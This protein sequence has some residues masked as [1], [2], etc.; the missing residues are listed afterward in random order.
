M[1]AV[2][3]VALLILLATSCLY[4]DAKLSWGPKLGFNLSQHYGTKGAEMDYKVR[5]GLRPGLAAGAFLEMEISENLSLM[6]ELLYT[7]KGSNENITVY[8]IDEAGDGVMVELPKPA[9]MK[10]KYY[11]DYIEIPVV[12]K[13]KMMDKPKFSIFTHA[14][15]AMSI[16]VKGY[17]QLDGKVYLTNGAGFD[18]LIV[19]AESKLAE[20]NMFDFSFVYGGE[21]VFKYKIPIHL[22]YRFTLGWDYLSLPTN[23]EYDPSSK[24]VE[25][26]NQ[27]YSLILG[28]RF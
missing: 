13:V 18:E 7:Q 5:T 28:T 19:Y 24:P 10:V 4:A 14:G 26:R 21:F 11:L 22:E 12:F 6:Y 1:R 17:R 23:P 8:R 2:F 25:L 15:S 20:V 27:T 9:E 16:K 3:T